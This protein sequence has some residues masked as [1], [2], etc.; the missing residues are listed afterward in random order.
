MGDP[1]ARQTLYEFACEFRNRCEATGQSVQPSRFGLSG[2]P[3]ELESLLSNLAT[4][5][6]EFT[7]RR[8]QEEAYRSLR[9]S[10][11]S[12]SERERPSVLTAQLTP[13]QAAALAGYLIAGDLESSPLSFQAWPAEP[14]YRVSATSE[15]WRLSYHNAVVTSGSPSS[16]PAGV[17]IPTLDFLM[18]LRGGLMGEAAQAMDELLEP[19]PQEQ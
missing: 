19:I 7:N 2:H 1:G 11:G 14:Y 6:A 12:P 13:I 16:S 4:F 18:F 10:V 8:P 3:E 15:G 5:D 17:R 9:L